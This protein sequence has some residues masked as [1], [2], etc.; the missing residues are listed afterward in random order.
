MPGERIVR[1][2]QDITF[3]CGGQALATGA[4]D[5]FIGKHRVTHCNAQL[6]RV[7]IEA[8]AK[9]RKGWCVHQ[10]GIAVLLAPR[11]VGQTGVSKTKTQCAVAGDTAFREYRQRIADL[12]RAAFDR[13]TVERNDVRHGGVRRQTMM[14][15]ALTFRL[16]PVM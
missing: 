16:T 2:R 10:R 14:L 3:D 15:P 7:C 4:I 9:A 1:L 5:V 13:I 12:G 8:H 11:G 6:P